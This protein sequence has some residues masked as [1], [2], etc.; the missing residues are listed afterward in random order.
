MVLVSELCILYLLDAV[1][2]LIIIFAALSPE[3][4]MRTVVPLQ[5]AILVISN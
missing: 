4:S 5:S 1:A 2:V 3:H